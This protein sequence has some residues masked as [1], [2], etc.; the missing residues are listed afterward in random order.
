MF[1]SGK[2]AIKKAIGYESKGIVYKIAS[3]E[4]QNLSL[5]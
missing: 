2:M 4:Y 3:Q 5:A 1:A